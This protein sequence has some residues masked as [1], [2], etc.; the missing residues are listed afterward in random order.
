MQKKL[1]GKLLKKVLTY[2]EKESPKLYAELKG[3]PDG[4]IYISKIDAGSTYSANI[5]EKMIAFFRGGYLDVG[6]IDGQ[7]VYLPSINDFCIIN[8]INVDVINIWRKEY[9][10][11]AYAIKI[12]DMIIENILQNEVLS[13]R[14]SSG[15]LAILKARVGGKWKDEKETKN[16]TFNILLGNLGDVQGLSS[17]PC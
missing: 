6:V 3:D 9:K 12:A 13:A 16:H 2:L 15:A 1:E 7:K 17:P 5:P 8:K 14:N 10:E 4:D 11:L